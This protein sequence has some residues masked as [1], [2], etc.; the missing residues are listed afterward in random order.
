MFS[1]ASLFS[2]HRNP[3]D[4]RFGYAILGTGHGAEKLCEALAGSKIARVAAIVSSS[5]ERAAKF[6]KRWDVTHAYSYDQVSTLAKDTSIDA[7]YIALPVSLH[8]RFTEEAAAAC[9]HVLC[10]K[11]MAGNVVD[12]QAMI[13]A[14]KA[15]NRLLMIGYRLDYDPMHREAHRLIHGGSLGV[16]QHVRANFGVVAKPGWRFDPALAGGGS[17]FDVGVYPIHG[18]HTLFGESKLIA[19]HIQQ[20]AAGM[21][22]D[23]R[24]QGKIES[25][26]SF[27]CHSSYMERDAD[28]LAVRGSLGTLTL[29]HAFDYKRT[30]LEAQLRRS[31]GQL[32]TIS[33]QDDKKNPSLFQLEAEHLAECVREGTT[34]RSPGEDGLIDLRF[35]AQIE[36]HAT[37]TTRP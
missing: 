27:T 18:L 31:P 30:E 11:P 6:G 9:K 19:A 17:L 34:L 25:N 4:G 15:A 1:L 20:N 13:T 12:A 10:E 32:E 8:R 26:A 29:R 37:R 35:V 28:V 3:D 36:A 24:W 16:I 22:V 14:C 2:R 5:V 33:M 21:E 23:A 7:V